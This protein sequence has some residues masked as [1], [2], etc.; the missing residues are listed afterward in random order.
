MGKQYGHTNT[1]DAPPR[2]TR[3]SSLDTPTSSAVSY[4]QSPPHSYQHQEHHSSHQ[5]KQARFAG[6][7]NGTSSKNQQGETVQGLLNNFSK[8][9]GKNSFLNC[10]FLYEKY[11]QRLQSPPSISSLPLFKNMDILYCNQ[12]LFKN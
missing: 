10:Y 4:L 7:P 6:G 8:A 1:H 9:L 11:S 2:Y 3:A 5:Q 12:N